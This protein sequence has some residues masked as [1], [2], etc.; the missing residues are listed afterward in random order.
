MTSQR[1]M[2]LFFSTSPRAKTQFAKE[3]AAIY[4]YIHDNV[5]EL[6]DNLIEKITPEMFYNMSEDDRREYYKKT[7]EAIKKAEALIPLILQE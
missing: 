7:I 2:K 1:P 5:Y 6:T 4:K 3:I